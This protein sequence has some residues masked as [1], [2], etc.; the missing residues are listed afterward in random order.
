[1]Y[2]TWHILINAS[3]ASKNSHVHIWSCFPSSPQ[4]KK[5]VTVL[6]AYSV[7]ENASNIN[8]TVKQSLRTPLLQAH[9]WIDCFPSKF[10]GWSLNFS[11]SNVASWNLEGGV[12]V[13]RAKPSGMDWCLS[14]REWT[15][16]GENLTIFSL[17][18]ECPSLASDF[19][20]VAKHHVPLCRYLPNYE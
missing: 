20:H 15:S 16:C 19:C 11:E 9:W 7:S 14:Q 17:C 18:H 13:T 6:S 5:A 4:L 2:L 3:E 12:W 8:S 1:M 10:I